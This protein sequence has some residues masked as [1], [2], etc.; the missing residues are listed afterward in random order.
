M[1]GQPWD[2]R[3][4]GARPASRTGTGASRT[5]A[6]GL[7]APAEEAAEEAR[8]GD[9]GPE[10]VPRQPVWAVSTPSPLAS[11]ARARAEAGRL[12]ARSGV[13]GGLRTVT[14]GL[15]QR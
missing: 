11:S 7:P 1:C 13:G 6:G 15:D 14:L 10:P 5:A 4:H 2:L 3:V 12:G 9:A 8:A